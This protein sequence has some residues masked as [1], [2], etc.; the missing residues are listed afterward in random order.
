MNYFIASKITKE[1]FFTNPMTHQNYTITK[2]SYNNKISISL[3]FYIYVNIHK[4][5]LFKSILYKFVA[6]ITIYWEISL[7]ALFFLPV[8]KLACKTGLQCY[9]FEIVFLLAQCAKVCV[10]SYNLKQ[11][12]Y[13]YLPHNL[14]ET[15]W[16]FIM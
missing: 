3:H 4:Q 14:N 15:A 11:V 10:C 5:I 16:K 8:C 2:Y 12:L 1:W 9:Y 13:H 6:L 7:L